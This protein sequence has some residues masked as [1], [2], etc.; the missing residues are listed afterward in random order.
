VKTLSNTW[1]VTD[2]LQVPLGRLI[3]EV[4]LSH[5]H[6]AV[7]HLFL[8]GAVARRGAVFGRLLAPLADAFC[9]VND[10][11]ALHGAVATVRVHRACTAATSLRS[12]AFVAVALA[13]GRCCDHQSGGPRLL[14][15]AVLLLFLL[16]VPKDGPRATRLGS[17]SLWGRVS[18]T[19]LGGSG[20]LVGQS[21]ERGNSF[22]VMCGQLLQH[23]FIMYSLS[24]GCDDRSIRNTRYHSSHLGEAGD[25]LPEGLPWFL[26][27][28]ME[29]G[30]HTVLLVSTGEVLHEPRTE[31]FPGVD[32]SWGE[33]HESGP[34]RSRQG[35]MKIGCHH[36]GVSTCYRYG[37]NVHL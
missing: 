13:S 21:E 35:H 12:R 36:S 2:I 7:V 32:C 9:E 15:V 24:E 6:L 29:V 18:C 27:H 1:G 3:P 17:S 22:H 23:L 4:P 34:G 37:D 20:A 33:V 10:L 26:P 25:E 19:A 14:V 28:F 30:L 16:S 31:F 11:A 8:V 5:G